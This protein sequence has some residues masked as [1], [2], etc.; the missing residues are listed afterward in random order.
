[1]GCTI[2]LTRG[3]F[4]HSKL[5]VIDDDWSLFGSSN[6]DPRSLRLNFE[7]AVECYDRSL[8]GSLTRIADEKIAALHVG[9]TAYFRAIDA[10]M[11]LTDEQLLTAVDVI[12]ESGFDATSIGTI[13]ARAGIGKGTLYEYFESKE[14]VLFSIAELYT[15]RE[16]ERLEGIRHYIRDPREKLRVVIQ[17]YLEF[18]ELRYSGRSSLRRPMAIAAWSPPG[19]SWNDGDGL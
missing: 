8:T 17:A 12:A 13:A 18:Y 15:Q 6:W 5:M 14:Q 4:D 11:D 2:R 7:I 16:F 9:K 19:R 10:S 3:S 1:M